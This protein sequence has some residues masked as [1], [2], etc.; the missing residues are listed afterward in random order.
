MPT[1][2]PRSRTSS[3]CWTAEEGH[4][5]FC[6][7]PADG[8]FLAAAATL[9]VAR[10]AA[11]LP[12]LSGVRVLLP[13]LVLAPAL[14]RALIEAAQRPLLLPR[15]LTSSDLAADAAPP[16]EPDS[17]RALALYAALARRSWTER[18]TLWETCGELLALFDELHR[19]AAGLPLDAADFESQL[20]RAYELFGAEPLSAEARLV[21]ALW[22]A[23]AQGRPGRAAQHWSA[24]ERVAAAP[25]GPL[26]WIF[27]QEPSAA[28]QR[29]IAAY[30]T[31]ETCVGL[32][33]LRPA[34]ADTDGL[35]A[36]LE[37]A[38]PSNPEPPRPALRVRAAE[39]RQRF[40]TSPLRHRLCIVAAQSLEQEATT[41]ANAVRRWLA[42]GKRDIALIAADRAAARRTRALLERDGILIDDETGWKLSTTRAAA[43]L[44]AWCEL[45]EADAYHRD[46]LDLVKSPFVFGDLDAAAR[47][48]AA[49]QL[50]GH[51]G[52]AGLRAGLDRYAASLHGKA[53]LDL[54]REVV[55]RVRRA[56]Q[57]FAPGKQ[58]VAKWLEWL[59]GCLDALGALQPLA[60]DAAGRIIVELIAA[61]RGELA[62]ERLALDFA[63]WRAWLD[64]ELETSMFRDQGIAS[65]VC[66]THLAGIRLRRFDAAIVI[67]ADRDHLGA[68][69]R[70]PVFSNQAVRR[71]MGLPTRTDAARQ[72]RNDLAYLITATPAVLITWQARR[73]TEANLL[74]PEIDT[75]SLLHELAWGPLASL[76]AGDPPYP[77]PPP[78]TADEEAP[79]APADLLPLTLSA[80]AWASLIACPYQFFARY[81]LGLNE[82]E[83]VREAL[84]KRDYGELLHRVLWRFHR[85]YPSLAGIDDDVL[86]ASLLEIAQAEFGAALR[87]SF[88]EHAWLK[89]LERRIADYIAWQREREAHGW[90]YAEGEARRE[91]ML[92][93]GAGASLRLHGRLDRIDRAAGGAAVIDYKAQRATDLKTRIGDSDGDIQLAA[94]T[95]LLGD[96]VREAAYLAL[97]GDEVRSVRIEE[98]QQLAQAQ[99]QRLARVY[100]RMSAGAGLPAHGALEI[101]ARCEMVGLCR[102]PYRN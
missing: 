8:R 49:L 15:M 44:D 7:L 96:E 95:F 82:A 98:P 55:E 67:G 61:R 6:S 81:A 86:S 71:A 24:L 57:R 63:E 10:C 54:A 38:W 72:L 52:S 62:G 23:E 17:R 92:E 47:R 40:S 50:E 32:V 100:A 58:P 28:E 46:L 89:R 9:I 51:L 85:R 76:P 16:A 59:H 19:R 2:G 33:P 97:D 56:A 29:F 36:L 90:R 80:S 35:A 21:H 34:A 22:F 84:E 87:Y 88:F 42:E 94:Y 20:E 3:I 102:R 68:P 66:M 64:R 73:G 30:A 75:L 77:D 45:V 5:R 69:S 18:S 91:R 27:D 25:A 99:T 83:Q 11:L 43:L 70:H 14:R 26:F 74:A 12:D 41:A 78:R 1:S 37:G 48:T 79:V 93:F 39:L 65:P 60:A 31:R 53:G 101:C 13:S 4:P